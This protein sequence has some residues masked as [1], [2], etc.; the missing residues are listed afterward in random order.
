MGAIVDKILWNKFRGLVEED[1]AKQIQ[2]QCLVIGWELYE[3]FLKPE[4]CKL[5]NRVW[6]GVFTTV[7]DGKT[8]RKR[9]IVEP[10]ARAEWILDAETM[11]SVRKDKRVHLCLRS[12]SFRRSYVEEELYEWHFAGLP[13]WKLV[14]KFENRLPSVRFEENR[15]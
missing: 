8:S 4:S 6:T 2:I 5:K 14:L 13:D 11:Q 12:A 3:W 7:E 9:L 1:A 10:A 15:S